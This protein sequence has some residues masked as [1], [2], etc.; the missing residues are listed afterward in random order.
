[1]RGNV[2]VHVER[3]KRRRKEAEHEGDHTPHCATPH[4]CFLTSVPCMPCPLRMRV[5]GHCRYTSTFHGRPLSS[6]VRNKIFYGLLYT[7]FAGFTSVPS[8]RGKEGNG[9]RIA[10]A[11]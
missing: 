10:D 7:T 6:I 9:P 5:S 2:G 1:M 4:G 3:G 11:Q 8:K